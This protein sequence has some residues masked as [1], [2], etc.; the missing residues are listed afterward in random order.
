[1]LRAKAILAFAD[2]PL[3]EVV[4]SVFGKD[5]GLDHDIAEERATAV[6][7]ILTQAKNKTSD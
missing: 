7:V 4:K 5:G 1:M 6:K 2:I 3:K